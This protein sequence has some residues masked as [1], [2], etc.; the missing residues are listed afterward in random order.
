MK[1]RMKSSWWVNRRYLSLASSEI[2]HDRS[3]SIAKQSKVTKNVEER[4]LFQLMLGKVLSYTF[5]VM[6]KKQIIS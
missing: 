4:L 2:K 1:G 5:N 6:R 3:D